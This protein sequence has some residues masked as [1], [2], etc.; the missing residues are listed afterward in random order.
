MT[1]N[2]AAP[3]PRSRSIAAK[4]LR[5]GRTFASLA[6]PV[7]PPKIWVL[8][9]K[10]CGTS[11]AANFISH[12]IY[13]RPA[14]IDLPVRRWLQKWAL[15]YL[16]EREPR[17]AVEIIGRVLREPVVKEPNLCYHVRELAAALDTDCTIVY[18][19][20]E[21]VPHVRSFLD[22]ILERRADGVHVRGDLNFV[23][24]GYLGNLKRGSP[25]SD[26]DLG[27]LVQ[28]LSARFDEVDQLC[29]GAIASARCASVTIRYED[30]LEPDGS[31]FLRNALEAQWPSFDW[32]RARRVLAV[33]HQPRGKRVV[34]EKLIA[35][36]TTPTW[37]L[38]SG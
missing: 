4:I 25:V 24:G 11:L 34:D 21:R 9:Q 10:K 35:E 33:Q 36:L 22:R 1:R 6:R 28:R 12:G 37:D 23:W 15:P 7:T 20:R 8:G 14:A 2:E 3:S 30:V 29:R 5:E 17:L 19:V 16:F 13:G 18:V 31:I 32:E 38:V 27:T 26:S